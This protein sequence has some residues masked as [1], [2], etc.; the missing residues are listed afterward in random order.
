MVE[1]KPFLFV[2]RP[3]PA[4]INNGVHPP[5]RTYDGTNNNMAPQRAEWGAADVPLLREMPAEYGRSDPR[6]AMG[7]GNRPSARQISN[8]LCDE[9]V[10]I[11]NNRNLSAFVY[12]WGQFLD[13]DLT[14][15]P[16]GTSEYLPVPLPADEPLFTLPIPFFR[17]EIRAG[18]GTTNP[19]QQSNLN[20]AWIDASVVYGSDAT[21]A[22]WLRTRKKG[23]LK[24]SAGNLLPW[25]TTTGEQA[26]PI[27]PTAPSMANDADHT[28]KTFVAGDVRAGEHPGITAI[29]TI[30]VREHNRICDRLVAQ[31]LKDDEELFQRARKEIGALIQAITYQEFL[32]AMGVTLSPYSGY[33]DQVQPDITN[34]FATAAYRIGHTMVA[35]ELSMRDNNCRRVGTGVLELDEA[36]FDPQIIATYGPDPFLKGFSTHKMYETNT[37]IN[38]VLRNFLFG[39][40]TAAVRFGLDLASLNIQRGRDHG[41]PAY[42]AVR[43]F[44][45]GNP[46]QHVGQITANTTQAAALK[47]L[48]G[49]VNSIDLWVGLLAEDLLPGKSVGPTMHAILKT[50][51]ERLRDGD[52]YFFRNDPFLPLSVRDQV[53]NTRLSEVIRR[54]TSLSS[55]PD[56]VFFA[57][58][59]PGENGETARVGIETLPN[60]M[61]VNLYPNPAQ[62]V[63]TVDVDSQPASRTVRIVGLDGTLLKQLEIASGTTRL[64]INVGDL[65]AGLYLLKVS[66]AQQIKTV[67]FIKAGH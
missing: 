46:V 66:S 9:P 51:F 27:D 63:L 35:D 61:T 36:F 39:S 12:V 4:P 50:Q 29:H 44:Y 45:T 55:M 13:H 24:T 43:A 64:T 19:R 21:R 34:L 65:R 38:S 31:G 22:N 8:V 40:P 26:D 11:F 10:T 56:N 47:G 28:A 53:A 2:S 49:D 48:Y 14:L 41:L 25:N 23:K 16:T 7:G 58:P 54:N 59:C 60:D 42:P 1:G 32:P 30:F 17:S 62:Q 57:T 15:T 18:S 33:R 6:N 52:F 20:T 5:Y 3:A 67:R 37:R